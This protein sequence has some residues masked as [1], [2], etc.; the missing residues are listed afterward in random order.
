MNDDDI[1]TAA[2]CLL[3]SCTSQI[4]MSIMHKGRQ[5]STLVRIYLHQCGVCRTLP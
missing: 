1:A 5:R 4:A 3:C 2:T